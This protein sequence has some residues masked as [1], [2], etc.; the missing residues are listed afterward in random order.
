MKE[1][2]QELVMYLSNRHRDAMISEMTLA[3]NI[4]L[5]ESFEDK[6]V[7]KLFIDNDKLDEYTNKL[8]N[9]YSISAYGPEA[10][11]GGLSGGNQQKLICSREVSNGVKLIVLDQPTRG[12]DLGAINYVH[13]TVIEACKDGRAILLVSTELSEVFGLCDRI[14][15]IYQGKIQGI[16][17]PDQLTSEKIGLLMAGWNEKEANK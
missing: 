5:K 17:K 16:Y 4:F 14:G 11:S 12:L 2:K 1:F 7:K 10:K 8:I 15:F 6:W 9:D 13:N 3:E